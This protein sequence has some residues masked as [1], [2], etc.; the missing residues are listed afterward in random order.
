[1]QRIRS[2]E[3]REIGSLEFR[4]RAEWIGKAHVQHC[5]R[6]QHVPKTGQ[7]S[8]RINLTDRFRIGKRFEKKQRVRDTPNWLKEAL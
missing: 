3:A 4:L 7:G 5:F 1:M 6:R 2:S 8:D